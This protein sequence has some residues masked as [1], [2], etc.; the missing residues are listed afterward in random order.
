MSAL[1]KN[2]GS[3]VV[4]IV[5][6]VQSGASPDELIA[7]LLPTL[8]R[9]AHRFSPAVLGALEPE[10]LVQVGAIEALKFVSKYDHAKRGNETFEAHVYRRAL[11]ACLEYIRLHAHAIHLPDDVARG[12]R[13]AK[14]VT[15]AHLPLWLNTG[16]DDWFDEALSPERSTEAVAIPAAAED[17][18]E[19]QL[20]TL[21][22]HARLRRAVNRLPAPLSDVVA[23]VWG[24]GRPKRG[25]RDIARDRGVSPSRVQKELKRGEAL[26]AKMLSRGR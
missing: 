10:D 17:T 23:W 9:V 5:L 18:P 4:E 3:E 7:L 20:I 11:R 14:G 16:E 15:P 13:P 8:Q 1:T 19:A 2:S 22:E 6:K 24:I 25:I 21:Q 12:R 26:L